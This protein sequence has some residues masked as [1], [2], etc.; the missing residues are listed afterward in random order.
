MSSREHAMFIASW[1]HEAK[2]TVKLLN[3]LPADK[4]DFPPRCAP[5][6]PPLP[7]TVPRA[8]PPGAARGARG[9]A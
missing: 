6:P 3:A 8:P 4:Y 2:S 9:C 7:P 1:E 5:T